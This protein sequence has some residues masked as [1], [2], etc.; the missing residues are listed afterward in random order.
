MKSGVAENSGGVFGEAKE[1]LDAR[2]GELGGSGS[3]FDGF[4]GFCEIVPGKRV[5]VRAND[6][7]GITLPGIELMFLGGADG[8]CNDLEHILG[9]VAVAIVN[10]NGNSDND[11]P[12]ELACGLRGNGSDE[13]A[14]SEAAGADLNWLE[15]AGKSAT[16][17]NGFDQRTL[18]EHDRIASGEVSRD[19]SQRNLHVFKMFGL[20]YAFDEISKAMIAGEAEARDAPAGDIAKTN[21]AAGG[22]NTCEGSAAGVSGSED[23]ADAGACD[24]RYGDVILLEDLQYPEMRETAG[25]PA[26]QGESDARA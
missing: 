3:G 26:T 20:E 11:G 7:V 5:D 6:Q 8:A 22:K 2:N 14:I 21:G 17:T 23:A 25:E 10:A 19:D 18:T 15:Q 1:F 4:V 13:G 9:R 24:V 12:A 16:G